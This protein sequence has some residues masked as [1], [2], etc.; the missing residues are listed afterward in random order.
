M[1]RWAQYKIRESS[2]KSGWTTGLRGD[3]W[4]SDPSLKRDVSDYLGVD[5]AWIRS[6]LSGP[7][8]SGNITRVEDAT[9]HLGMSNEVVHLRFKRRDDA[10]L[11][12]L[13]S[14]GE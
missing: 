6:G 5:E 11:F 8:K 10:L 3:R 12:K 4:Q 1:S 14:G 7:G 2:R 9:M 13:M